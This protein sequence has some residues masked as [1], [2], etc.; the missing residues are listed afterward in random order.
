MAEEIIQKDS[1]DL[2]KDDMVT[3]TIES[4]MRRAFPDWRDGLKLVQRRILTDMFFNLPARYKLIKSSRVTGDTMGVYHPHGDTA[5]YDAAKV[6]ANWFDTYVPLITPHGN[7]GSMQGEG[8][9][10]QRYT[11]MM[12][13][14]FTLDIMFGEL[15]EEPNITDWV[16][17]YDYTTKEPEFLPAALPVLLINGTYGIGTGKIVSIPPHNIGDVIDATL[18]LMDDPNAEVVLRPDQRMPCEII[19]TNWK[20]ICN[21]GHGSFKVRAIIDTEIFDKGT[22]KE[23]PVLV[24]KSTPDFVSFDKGSKENGGVLYKIHELID[25]GKLPQ[26]ESIFED[27]H[28]TN[29]RVLFHLK[30]GS[31]PEYVKQ[32]LYKTTQLEKT[33]HVNFEVLNGLSLDRF[34]YK[35]YLQ[36]FIEQRKLTKFR[37]ASLALQAART[38]YHEMDAF[39]KCIESDMLDE[40]IHRIRTN[41]KDDEISNIEWL[42]KMLKITDLQAKFILNTRLRNLAPGRITK[43]KQIF[44]E[45]KEKEKY[46][47]DRIL[48]ESIIVEDIRNE[49]LTF[50]KKYNF[51]N[52][53]RYVSEDD[54]SN[55]PQGE[56]KVVVTEANYIK[57]LPMG[58]YIG[59]Y[60]GDNP[61][62]IVK[63]SNT[64]DIL[65]FTAQG[66]VYKLP[67]HKIPISEK[68]SAGVDLRILIRGLI[69]DVVAVMYL[70]AIEEMSRYANKNYII[71]CT[72]YNKI[73]KMDLDDF[74]NTP[75]SGIIYSKLSNGDTVKSVAVAPDT[76]DLIIYSGKKALRCPMTDIPYY[77]RN[78]MGVGAMSGVDTIDGISVVYPDST[79][80][81]VITESGKIN[82]FAISG[83]EV[84]NRNKSG[85]K[86]IT[87]AKNG[88]EINSIFGVNDSHILHV[89]TRS[90]K[91]D[92][93]VKE[94]ARASSIAKGENKIST[95]G[96]NIVKIQVLKSN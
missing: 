21:S 3:Y 42:C 19:D 30:R 6:M 90:T 38:K 62:H 34:S 69:S 9:A 1:L 89:I 88:D 13:S 92:I 12:I 67:V 22:A 17:N 65:L 29:M 93:P 56:F 25:T 82:K 28:G 96:D 74:V 36:A 51:P 66:V 39:I 60:R 58:E 61:V 24:L 52:K 59:S 7:F 48:N 76:L 79:D 37:L 20:L 46:C 54:I 45:C 44:K 11:E 49:L 75:P 63:V 40:I 86:V 72:K 50:K 78:T 8:Q 14:Q 55:I 94:L 68:G 35:S 2:Y 91:I 41:G 77:K 95:K 57:K 5:I 53:C 26:I 10:A 31:D 64:K 27:S 23:H 80:I 85:S 4:N 43:Y 32:Y 84:S 71:T 18:R 81:V 70:P 83:M 33:Q 16:P 87:L 47:L 73:K 15:G